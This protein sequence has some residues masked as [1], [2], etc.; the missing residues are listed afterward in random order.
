MTT[1]TTDGRNAFLMQLVSAGREIEYARKEFDKQRSDLARRAKQMA[2]AA[3]R[4]AMSDLAFV[5]AYL[6]ATTEAKARLDVAIEK[7]KTLHYAGK[8]AI[9][10]TADE[11]AATTGLDAETY[12]KAVT[13]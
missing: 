2:D 5:Q 7:L 4:V 8:L 11:F 13:K 1:T 3:T 6:N 9:A 12:E 10:L